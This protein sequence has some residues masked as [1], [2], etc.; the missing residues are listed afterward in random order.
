MPAPLPCM[1]AMD[2]ES[3]IYVEVMASSQAIGPGRK[4][5]VQHALQL[6]D[7]SVPDLEKL[8]GDVEGTCRLVYPGLFPHGEG[9]VGSRW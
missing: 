9:T 4:A 2:P 8:W 7:S 3:I 5:F 6:I 1:V